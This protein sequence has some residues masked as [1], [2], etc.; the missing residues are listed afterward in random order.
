MSCAGAYSVA[1]IYRTLGQSAGILTTDAAGMR[2]G[3]L[4]GFANGFSKPVW[5]QRL[6]ICPQPM[7][8]GRKT[9]VNGKVEPWNGAVQEVFAPIYKVRNTVTV[10]SL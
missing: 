5:G 8:D 9:L 7:V 10:M 6:C 1:N 4:A 3:V 2:L